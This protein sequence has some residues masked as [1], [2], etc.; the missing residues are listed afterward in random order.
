VLAGFVHVPA[1][2]DLAVPTSDVAALADALRVVVQ[3]ALVA[4]AEAAEKR[5]FA[6]L[7]AK[8]IDRYKDALEKL[9]RRVT[10]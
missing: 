7:V 1:I 10:R 3:T 8:G 9:A 5:P 2:G 6:S 4:A